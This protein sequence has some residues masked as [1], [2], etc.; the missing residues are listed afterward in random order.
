MMACMAALIQNIR[1]NNSSGQLNYQG[2]ASGVSSLALYQ[3]DHT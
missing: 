3:Y 1:S 2:R